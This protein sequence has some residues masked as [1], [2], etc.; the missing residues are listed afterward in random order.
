MDT[1]GVLVGAFVAVLLLASCSTAQQ[2]ASTS[3]T[4]APAFVMDPAVAA[5]ERAAVVERYDQ[6]AAAGA[7]AVEAE[8]QRREAARVAA[9]QAA[10]AAAEQA[11]A[12]QAA[13]AEA[14]RQAAEAAAAEEEAQTA[15]PEPDLYDTGW[16]DA[17]GWVSPETAQRA[18]QAGIQAGDTVPN[19]LRC[20]TICGESPTSGEVQQQADPPV[21]SFD[22]GDS[23]LC[24]FQVRG[25]C[26]PSADA[27]RAAGEGE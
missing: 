27:A 20:G 18:K 6:Q 8:N 26:Y 25:T 15:E 21:V 16:Y 1:R 17:R 3:L 12:S 24:A 14:D 19:Y 9:A 10:Q 2:E 4:S 23:A 22:D 7:A 13:Q 11:A 5:K